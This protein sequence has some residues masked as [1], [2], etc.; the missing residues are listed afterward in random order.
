MRGYGKVLAL[1]FVLIV[2][3]GI[4]GGEAFTST[5]TMTQL[6]SSHVPSVE[7]L[8]RRECTNGLYGC[9]YRYISLGN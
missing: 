1:I 3:L 2:V 5:G 4:V 6:Q 8:E 9:V 7:E